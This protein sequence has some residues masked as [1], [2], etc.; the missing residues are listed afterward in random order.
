[1]ILKKGRKFKCK[2]FIQNSKYQNL[3]VIQSLKV[4][5][6]SNSKLNKLKKY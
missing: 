5:G 3:P 2:G 6:N 4:G 1:M